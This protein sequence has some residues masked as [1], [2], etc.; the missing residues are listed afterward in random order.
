MA[1]QNGLG[2][3]QIFFSKSRMCQYP[4]MLCYILWIQ[5]CIFDACRLSLHNSTPSHC[6]ST[7]GRVYVKLPSFTSSCCIWFLTMTGSAARGPRN[8][9]IFSFWPS[10][11]VIL[12]LATSKPFKSS[13]ISASER[14][15]EV[16]SSFRLDHRVSVSNNIKTSTVSKKHSQHKLNL[17]WQ[18][19]RLS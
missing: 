13:T 17:S 18:R 3:G 15:Q 10:H 8:E 16:D 14:P 6:T 12:A 2:R 4:M 19:P 9:I 5:K 11:A 1:I 7:E